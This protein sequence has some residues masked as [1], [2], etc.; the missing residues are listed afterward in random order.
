MLFVVVIIIVDDDEAVFIEQRVSLDLC[1]LLIHSSSTF[2]NEKQ[3]N[4][5]RKRQTGTCTM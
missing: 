2:Y 3:T 5:C 1:A 4:F